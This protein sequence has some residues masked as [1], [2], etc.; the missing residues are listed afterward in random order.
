MSVYPA[1]VFAGFFGNVIDWFSLGS[2]WW[3]SSGI[4]ARLVEHAEMSGAAMVAAILLAVPAAVWF[5]HRRRFGL[6]A[7]NVSNI[8]RAIPSFAILVIG[9]QLFGL[10]DVPIVGSW[11]VFVALVVL[12]IPPMVTNAYVGMAEVPDDLRD[13]GRGMGLSER[14]QLFDVELPVALPLILGGIRT[15]AVQVVA[16]ATIAAQV[17]SGGLGRFI[18]EGLALGPTA[19]DEVFAGALLVALFALATEGVLA[20]VQR[21][22]TPV[23][24]RR[25][26]EAALDGAPLQKSRKAS[27]AP[28]MEAA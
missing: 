16:T 7:I 11:F 24:L 25:A 17:G 9:V 5:G 13:A 8:G 20:L 18:I 23:G 3:G 22:V 14:Q 26:Q 15:S 4:M 6:A 28:A 19:N 10:H 12:A 21:L 1:P 2:N 27:P